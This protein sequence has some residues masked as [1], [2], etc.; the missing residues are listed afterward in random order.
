MGKM[1]A[2]L[3]M[4]FGEMILEGEN[5]QEIIRLLQ[6]IPEDFIERISNLVTLK[7]TPTPS[8]QLH[9]LVEITTEG[10]VIVTAEKLTHYEAIGIVLYASEGK[11]NTSATISRLLESSG[12]RSMVPARLNEMAKRGHVFKPNPNRAEY[13]LTVQG[14]RWVEDEVLSRL[15]G[16]MG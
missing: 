8:I 12:I 11:E 3:K 15:G 16:K 10:P 6:E 5:P 14:E 2:K 13:R 7:L 4:P 9:G 1:K